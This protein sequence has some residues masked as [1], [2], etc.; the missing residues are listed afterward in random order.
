MH[1]QDIFM[2]RSADNWQD[3][4]H[5]VPCDEVS[6][7]PFQFLPGSTFTITLL[8]HM[9]KVILGQETSFFKCKSV[10]HIPPA[11]KPVPIFCQSNVFNQSE[12]T[13][14]SGSCTSFPSRR[15][16]FAIF[17][18]AAI[19]LLKRLEAFHPDCRLVHRPRR[20][21]YTYFCRVLIQIS[22]KMQLTPSQS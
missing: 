16:P 4:D 11:C 18:N 5:E 3:C 10:F 6:K 20:W 7:L 8:K 14:L 21:L 13:V 1:C 2:K 22:S 19:S 17:C 9:F 15:L 12:A